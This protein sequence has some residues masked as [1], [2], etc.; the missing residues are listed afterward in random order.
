VPVSI[1]PRQYCWHNSVVDH[2][3]QVALILRNRNNKSILGDDSKDVDTDLEIAVVSL[4]ELKGHTLELLGTH[5]NGN[6]YGKTY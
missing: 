5:V 3:K 6:P 4:S 2:E 1:D